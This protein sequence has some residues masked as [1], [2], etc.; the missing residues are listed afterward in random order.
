MFAQLMMKLAWNMEKD[1]GKALDASKMLYKED[2][3]KEN[4]EQ[5]LFIADLKEL[6]DACDHVNYLCKYLHTIG[7]DES[8][9]KVLDSLPEAF[10]KQQFWTKIRQSIVPS[11]KWAKDE[12]CYFAN[13]GAPHFEKWD[14]ESYKQG[15]GGSET[16]VCE[17][18]KQ[19]AKAGYKVTVYGDPFKEGII[20]GVRYISWAKFNYKDSFNIVI[21]WR[22]WELAGRI[23]CRRF[24]VD[25]HDVF[26]P[27][28]FNKRQLEFIDKIF[29][30]SKYHRNLA[31]T[32]PDSK[33]IISSN[34][35]AS[36]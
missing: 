33:F 21:Q 10:T 1:V 14:G 34:G 7:D 23:K 25:L 6:N 31:P 2:P 20:D 15:I 28:D 18:S 19:F 8:A 5:V 26:I 9:I 13:F 4:K 35:Y 30:K 32:I 17:M 11:R 27:L 24:Y 3:I 12:I 16:A 22:N 36:T 29:V